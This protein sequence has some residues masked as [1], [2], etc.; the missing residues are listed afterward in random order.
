LATDLS[1]N[2]RI[3][4]FQVTEK[5]AKWSKLSARVEKKQFA[6]D[7]WTNHWQDK[8]EKVKEEQVV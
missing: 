3:L 5:V 7:V 8:L 2:A 4:L 1:G 6:F